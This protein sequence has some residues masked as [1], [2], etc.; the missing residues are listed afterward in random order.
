MLGKKRIIAAARFWAFFAR[1]ALGCVVIWGGAF[2]ALLVHCG[3]SC[4]A[5]VVVLI[6]CGYGGRLALFVPCPCPLSVGAGGVVCFLR[7]FCAA[8]RA[9]ASAAAAAALLI[10][11]IF[12]ASFV[13]LCRGRGRCAA[14]GIGAAGLLLARLRG[15]PAAVLISAGAEIMRA[16][17][18]RPSVVNQIAIA[19]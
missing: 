13:R 17:C 16:G 3:A 7:L 9:A 19:G 1:G 10:Y 2:S 12:C 6:F 8:R 11:V 15:A 5:S 18:R 4:A 14:A